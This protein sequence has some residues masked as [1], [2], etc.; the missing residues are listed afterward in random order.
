MDNLS[1]V[2]THST[3]PLAVDTDG[4][5]LPD[6]WE[7]TH[8]INPAFAGDSNN[9]F[10]GDD[11]T[12]TEAFQ[13]GLQNN[14]N[15][16]LADLDG[17]NTANGEDA[18]PLDPA[19]NWKRSP[20]STYAW[21]PVVLP[22]SYKPNVINNHLDVLGSLIDRDDPEQKFVIKTIDGSETIIAADFLNPPAYLDGDSMDM[23]L[24]E[25]S[26]GG[27]LSDSKDFLISGRAYIDG[28][29]I[30][31]GFVTMLYNAENE[32]WEWIG[33][34]D[35]LDVSTD[36]YVNAEH[37]SEYPDWFLGNGDVIATSANGRILMTVKKSTRYLE[38]EIFSYNA[39]S[40]EKRLN[41]NLQ[42]LYYS[43]IVEGGQAMISWYDKE[44]RYFHTSVWD[45][46]GFEPIPYTSGD[47]V[48]YYGIDMAHCPNGQ[49]WIIGNNN[50]WVKQN[51]ASDSW[52]EAESLKF[53]FPTGPYNNN[54][55]INNR[56]EVI[57]ES[58]IWRNTEIHPLVELC[59]AFEDL[60]ATN[61]KVIDS[62][63]TGAILAEVTTENGS[64]TEA[65]LMVPMEIVSRDKF[66]AGSFTI[67]EGWDSLEMEF[68]G[69]DGTLG[70]Y[71]NFLSSGSTKIYN[72]EEEIL[73]DADYNAGSQSD[74][75]KVW[76]VRDATNY[77]K[78][79]F[80]TCYDSTGET[81]IKLFLDED[82]EAF[83]EFQH[84]LTPA[85]D[86]A[87]I[88][89]YV[90][91]W[92]KGTSFGFPSTAGSSTASNQ[93][94]SDG[95]SSGGIHNLTRIALVPFFT[96]V[97]NVEGL[98]S[99]AVGLLDG[100][101]Q[102][103]I[104]DWNLVLLIK[105]GA[106]G[107]GGW[108]LQSAESELTK[109]V[110]DPLKRA[111]ELKKAADRLC[112]EWV[113]KPMA[114]IQADLSTWA[115]FKKR[116]WQTW[117]SVKSTGVKAWV[118]PSRGWDYVKIGLSS[119]VDDFA[120]RMMEGA[121]KAHWS[122]SIFVMDKITGTGNEIGR[123]ASYTF[124]YTLGYVCEQA[125]VGI[126]TGGTVKVASIMTKGGVKV[127]GLLAARRV[128]PVVA[129][130]QFLK[131]WAASVAISVE[132]K[133]AVEKGLT[134][135]AEIPLSAVIRDSVAEVIERGMARATFERTAFSNSKLLDQV[136]AALTIKK[137][138]LTPGREDQLWHKFALFFEVMGEKAT[139]PAAKGW[140]Q[141]YNRLLKFD[142]DIFEEDRADDLLS[143]FRAESSDAGK[144][145]LR[146][147]L[148]EF[149]TT[150]GTGKFWLRD[151]EKI[152][153]EGYRYSNFDPRFDA[154]GNPVAGSPKLGVNNENGW[155]VSFEKI[156]SAAAA[157]SR[158]Q[159]PATSTARY[160]LEFDWE[161][162]KDHINVPR[163][164]QGS[165]DWF[166]PL[167][168]DYPENG[169]G[170]GG[171]M[172]IDGVEVPIKAIWDIS[173]SSPVQIY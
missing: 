6:G 113:F 27:W 29:G 15:A 71:G 32:A 62:N 61:L 82:P 106:V 157:K 53:R 74:N 161:A 122:E 45:G 153:A 124:G 47:P 12:Y 147:S 34:P 7:I 49:L 37:E 24:T 52:V 160:R 67:P 78:L 103:A 170:S 135:A 41:P 129:R 75:Q 13:S 96:V 86:F 150:D 167:C 162:V 134:T 1:E 79:T 44:T 116:S 92:V 10:P 85:A 31:F 9:L 154:S 42:V 87:E 148:D 46:Q 80:Y 36:G 11:I 4:D 146:K 133:I 108:A 73:A 77:R 145:A 139:A 18:A 117:H 121:E 2:A 173:G 70:K 138:L 152:Q 76:F 60:P 120:D 115:G 166:E 22:D 30:E 104:D 55:G 132:M 168:R 91:E 84:T 66:I 100:I 114:D 136:L 171:Q 137:L 125:A 64:N 140:V 111:A 28:G 143:L 89:D 151:I 165:A 107:A 40:Y 102:G 127:A 17:D 98:T 105:N 112:E 101:K 88:I 95:E 169:A 54:N 59:P 119:W 142:G 83:C 21:I 33:N 131:K 14:P 3:N 43:D 97:N 126:A 72:S 57:G 110:S 164:R 8:G 39:Q 23:E 159:L 50:G 65:G 144:E 19:I 16:T 58:H 118:L 35:A 63:E 38:H 48:E 155:Y 69:P 158:F 163:G 99:V 149:G 5:T 172:L 20:E 56:G 81:Q 128:L 26:G 123:Q 94:S 130:L 141:A 90:D 51:E 156:N 68:T 109:W 93:I 25:I